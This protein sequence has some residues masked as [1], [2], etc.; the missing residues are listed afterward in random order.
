LSAFP[1]NIEII[2]RNLELNPS[3]ADKIA[4]VP[5]A[6]S[7]HFGD[8]LTFKDTGPGSRSSS[9]GSG[10]QVETQAIDDFVR[11][12]SLAKVDFIKMDIEGAEPAALIGAEQTIREHRPQLAISVYHDPAHLS[13]IP[14]WIAG[15]DLAYRFWLDHFTVHLEETVLFARA[16]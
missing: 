14:N 15:L 2:K 13:S 5:K 9:D 12:K 1:S 8:L 10:V 11:Q 16:N 7:S 4:I 3:L 6:L